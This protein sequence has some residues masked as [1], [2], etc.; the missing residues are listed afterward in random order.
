[1]TSPVK[2]VRFGSQHADDLFSGERYVPQVQGPIQY[3]HYHRYLFALKLCEGKDV[4]D[5][6][7]GEGYG[8]AL[9]TQ[10]AKSVV[11]VD[12]DDRAVET[13]QAR[14]VSDNLR[15]EAGGATRIR[16]PTRR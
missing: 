5:I 4:L 13:A 14:Y 3:E 15:F 2:R 8:S 6:A 7:S 11:G 16:C 9:L 1:M 10:G 12:I